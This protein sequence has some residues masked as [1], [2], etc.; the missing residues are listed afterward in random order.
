MKLEDIYQ[1][2]AGELLNVE[3]F[4]KEQL[5][6]LCRRDDFADK[7]F[8][9]FFHA[10]GK[11]LRPSLVLLSAYTLQQNNTPASSDTSSSY[12]RLIA[13]AAITELVHSASLMH[14]DVL[15]EASLRRGHPSLNALFGNKVAILAGDMLYSQ[16]FDLLA[17]IAGDRIIRLLAQCVRRMCRGEISNLQ[18]HDFGAY[19]A[20]IED[21]T[22]SFMAFCCQAGAWLADAQGENPQH[23]EALS[24]FGF[25]FGTVY[26]LADDLGDQDDAITLTCRDQVIDLLEKSIR[27]A[28]HHLQGL[29]PSVYRTSLAMLLQYVVSKSEPLAENVALPVASME[30]VEQ[31]C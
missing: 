11:K 27:Q 13:L 9:S 24:Q 1:P 19:R 30:L 12:H 4:I 17:E 31:R 22:S 23:I 25:C 29:P 2:I 26:Q 10:P 6:L 7:V 28:E 20:I 16:A 3:Q 18:G 5:R 15:D 21:K 8:R 14:D